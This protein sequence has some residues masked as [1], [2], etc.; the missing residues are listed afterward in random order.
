MPVAPMPP[1]M[2]GLDGSAASFAALD[3]GAEEAAGRV[4]PLEILH[5][6]T[7]DGLA[8]GGE[9]LAV[10]IGRVWADHPGLAVRGVLVLGEPARTLIQHAAGACLVVLGHRGRGGGAPAGPVATRVANRAPVP[11]IVA[12]PFDREH[13]QR[14]PRPILLGVDGLPCS[15]DAVGFAF[16]EAAQRGA[17]LE[18]H[19][20]WW[21]PPG[22]AS[23]C[24]APEADGGDAR[25]AARD[26]LAGAIGAWSAR[27]PDVPVR[28]T[29]EDADPV[30]ALLAASHD[31]Q[32]V[33]GGSH[34]HG[35]IAHLLSST[36]SQALIERAG[37]SVA[38]T[39]R[40]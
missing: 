29:V 38:V 11:V 24:C 34:D 26:R 37:C 6:S 21:E 9:A 20:V 33:V 15:E 35:G 39:Q 40:C 14:A 10:A 32:L 4:T 2:V 25:L 8:A 23:A 36:V 13:A 30:D 31:A 1:V 18:A 27:Y 28:A 3:L 7:V 22:V 5:V 17:A 12:R 19:H 16:E